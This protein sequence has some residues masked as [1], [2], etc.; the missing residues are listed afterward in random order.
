MSGQIP[1]ATT[2]EL[3]EAENKLRRLLKDATDRLNAYELVEHYSTFTD[4][5]AEQLVAIKDER[6]AFMLSM[7]FLGAEIDARDENEKQHARGQFRDT[8]RGQLARSVG[9][10]TWIAKHG[11]E[12]EWHE[13]NAGP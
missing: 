10:T 6:L 12:A 4:E 13:Y 2:L 3:L 1:A 9:V 8:A 11:S 5:Q 7:G